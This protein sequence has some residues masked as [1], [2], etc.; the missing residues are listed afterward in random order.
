MHYT[1]NNCGRKKSRIDLY[2][3]PGKCGRGERKKKLDLFLFYLSR[4][5]GGSMYGKECVRDRKGNRQK[6][7]AKS[8]WSDNGL[9]ISSPLLGLYSPLYI[10]ESG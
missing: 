7:A 8:P 10:S 9:P 2:P 6:V 3:S 4:M 1:R 5:H